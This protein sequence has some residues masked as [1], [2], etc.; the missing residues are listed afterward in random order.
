MTDNQEWV[1]NSPSW[2]LLYEEA[3][4]EALTRT[5]PNQARLINIGAGAGTSSAALLRGGRDIENFELLSIDLD[6]QFLKR[7]LDYLEAQSLYTPSRIRQFLGSSDE[8]FQHISGDKVR[9]NLVFVDGSHN[10]EQ[11]LKDI[12]NYSELLAPGGI[13]VCHDYGDP[14]QPDVTDAINT[15]HDE[16]EWFVLG[17]AIFTVAFLK[18]G[19]DLE[20][21]K[22]RIEELLPTIEEPEP[23][24]ETQ[25]VVEEAVEE[26][27]QEDE[28]EEV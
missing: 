6:G 24:E 22:G 19:G 28:P 10:G 9:L 15:W 26:K 25:E 18:P 21:T 1:S 16:S 8:A 7:E 3:F 13:L 11:V 12:Q 2:I 4:L 20:W 14:R 23:P 5:L 17:R 27:E